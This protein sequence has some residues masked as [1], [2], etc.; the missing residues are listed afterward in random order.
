MQGISHT[1]G[2]H[3]FLVIVA[4]VAIA[5]GFWSAV[6]S[7][8]AAGRPLSTV[9]ADHPVT[10]ARGNT[11]VL[12]RV[13]VRRPTNPAPS[14][15]TT[16]TP[17]TPSPAATSS[18]VAAAP[19]PAVTL[20]V[21]AVTTTC[22]DALDYLASHAAPGFVASCGPGNSMGRFGYTCWNVAPQCGNGGRIIHIAC[23]APFVYQNEAHNSWALIGQR[24][25]I[26]PY[27]Q[28]NPAEQAF[29]NRFR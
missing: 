20:V 18:I 14:F 27:G 6:F 26:D 21:P 11:T 15:T 10:D 4:S 24:S 16:T 7:T 13:D 1:R 25:G 3:T 23:P 9:R 22:A 12:A 19:A 28:G 29:C 17:P 8:G 2:A 5:L